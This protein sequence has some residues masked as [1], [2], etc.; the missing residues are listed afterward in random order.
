MPYPKPITVKPGSFAV[1]ADMGP[2]ACPAPGRV[3][4]RARS[5]RWRSGT[6]T[7]RRIGRPCV[8]GFVI[9]PRYDAG[10]ET[11]LTPLSD[12]EAFFALALH[13]VNLVPHGS[14]GTRGA[15][16]AGGRMPVLLADRCR[17][18]TR[19]AAWSWNWWRPVAALPRRRRWS[20]RPCVLSGR[21]GGS[22]PVRREGASA[23]ELDDNVALYDEVGQL[24]IMLNS[25]A[26]AVWERCD[27]TTTLDDMVRELAAAH[28]RRCAPC[29]GEDVR[30]T[31]RKLAELGLVVERRGPLRGVAA[32]RAAVE[33]DGAC[34]SPT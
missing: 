4:G 17:I 26:A 24:L 19:P 3:P 14:A 27:G 33:E 6:D 28:R 18:S 8:P 30:Q 29:I 25:S 7:G 31:V 21:D 22:R 20:G 34:P 1:L 16:P 12:T 10:A 5:G 23:V 13:A 11:A 32:A 2:D 9:V 15:R